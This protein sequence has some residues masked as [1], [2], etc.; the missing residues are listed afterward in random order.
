MNQ[1]QKQK[2]EGQWEEVEEI[3]DDIH[4]KEYGAT[5]E[6]AEKIQSVRD[7]LW[8]SIIHYEGEKI[9]TENERIKSVSEKSLRCDIKEL[10]EWAKKT[11]DAV[12]N[13]EALAARADARAKADPDEKARRVL[14]IQRSYSDV[15]K[16]FEDGINV[17][18]DND[19]N[20]HQPKE[21]PI[22]KREKSGGSKFD[23]DREGS[24]EWHLKTTITH[25]HEWAA[26][27][28]NTLVEGVQVYHGQAKPV[29]GIHYEGFCV[30]LNGDVYVLFHCYPKGKKK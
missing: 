28:R 29:D 1:G 9:P 12:K 3:L 7:R 14:E 27:L 19:Q 25:M 10:K 5:L 21:H 6:Q 16:E 23:G 15:G 13:P 24:K 11:L 2:L 17:W 26:G 18:I 30:M 20:K 8:G 22:G 4:G